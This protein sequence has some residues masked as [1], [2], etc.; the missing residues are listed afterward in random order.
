MAGR[1]TEKG[2][3]AGGA[4]LLNRVLWAKYPVRIS[5]GIPASVRTETA[6]ALYFRE[7]NFSAL[8]TDCPRDEGLQ[9]RAAAVGFHGIFRKAES[10][11]NLSIALTIFTHTSK[12]VFLRRE[13]IYLQESA[14]GRN[15]LQHGILEALFS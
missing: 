11:G 7:Q 1:I 9:A 5:P 4:L 3:F 14:T 13:H 10:R 6:A 15:A 2:F 8:W 12:R